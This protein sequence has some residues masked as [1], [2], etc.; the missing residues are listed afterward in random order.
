MSRRGR[1]KCMCRRKENRR[2]NEENKMKRK[3]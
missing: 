3:E 2:A 1:R